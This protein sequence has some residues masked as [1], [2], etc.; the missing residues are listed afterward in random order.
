VSLLW[1]GAFGHLFKKLTAHLEKRVPLV[2]CIW[3]N[4]KG[5]SVQKSPGL[6]NLAGAR[7]LSE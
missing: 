2:W 6:A 4:I 1:Y 7:Q 3:L 5:Y